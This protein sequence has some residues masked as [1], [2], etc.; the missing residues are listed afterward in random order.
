MIYL[1]QLIYIHEGQEHTFH[2][3]E[4]VAIPLIEKYKGKLLLRLRPTKENFIAGELA[5][6]YEIHLVSFENETDFEAFK[7]DKVRQEFL[8]L[9]EAS[10]SRIVLIQGTGS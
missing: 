4:D 1:T 7:Q 10:V 9:K 8:H 3:F 6:P 2:Q 5:L